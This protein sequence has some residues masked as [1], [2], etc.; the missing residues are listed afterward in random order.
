VFIGSVEEQQ[1]WAASLKEVTIQPLAR[2][3]IPRERAAELA[4][5]LQHFLGRGGAES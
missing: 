2:F 1:Q 5:L 3:R 4:E